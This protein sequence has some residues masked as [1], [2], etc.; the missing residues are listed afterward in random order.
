MSVSKRS[1]TVFVFA[2]ALGALLAGCDRSGDGA[3]DAEGAEPRPVK[4]LTV[5]AVATGFRRDYPAI[6]LPAQEVELSFRVSGQIVELPIRGGLR[7][8]AGEVVAQL[9]TRDFEAELARL[10][11]QLAQAEAQME[12]LTSGARG[13]DLAALEAGVAAAQ[14]EVDGATDR[15]E[16][17]QALFERNVIAEV[18]L[19]EDLIALRVAEAALEAKEQ[20]LAKGRAGAREEDVAAQQALI[21]G[22][23]LSIES[24]RDALEDATLRAPFDGIVARRLVENFSNVRAKDPIAVLQK[25]ETL[26]LSFDVPGPDVVKLAA[27]RPLSAEAVLDSLPG[28]R[29]AAEL[30]E[31]S[32]QADPAT[33]TYR[34]RVA[35]EVPGDVAILPGM[36][37]SVVVRGAPESEA[38][39]EIPLAALAAEADGT[40]F[41]WVVSEADGRVSRRVVVTGEARGEGIA[42]LEGLEA[43]DVVVT[44]GVSA[45]RDAMEV[46]PVT[47]IGE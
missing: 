42:V 20:E 26:A 5:R 17:S 3:G 13:E 40:P 27:T 41:V 14:A 22:L 2:V 33:Q 12:V 25:L 45:L 46:R 35:I 32:T 10:E 6:V 8:A 43:G 18:A 24:A 28:Q 21:D 1:C 9:D 29:F 34:G 30:E 16:R 36:V 15:V 38:A 37:G 19:D 23:A 7:I 47:G 4:T 39:H 44:A 11:S 31:F